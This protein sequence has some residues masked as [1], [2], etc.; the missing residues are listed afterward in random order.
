M[1]VATTHSTTDTV[2]EMYGYQQRNEALG[3]AGLSE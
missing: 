2:R 3:A 1:N